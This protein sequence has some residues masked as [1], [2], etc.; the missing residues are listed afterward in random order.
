MK[1][2]NSLAYRVIAMVLVFILALLFL[3]P[4]YWIVTGSFK[5]G[6]DINS[7]KPVW[8]PSEWTMKN[9]ETLMS[10]QKANLFDFTVPFSQYG[11]LAQIRPAGRVLAETHTETGTEITMMIAGEDVSRLIS[12]YGAGIV[13]KDG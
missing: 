2:R 3:F 4:L 5:T 10:K 6:Q 8:W 11:L 12:R 9:Y 7:T 1:A 13:K